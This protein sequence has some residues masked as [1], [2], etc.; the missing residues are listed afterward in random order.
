[1][2]ISGYMRDAKTK[3]TDS[4]F[5]AKVT[6]IEKATASSVEN[7]SNVQIDR[8]FENGVSVVNYFGH[9]SLNA[10]EFNLD[11]PSRFNNQGKYPLFLANA[12]TAG[13]N[14]FYDSLRILSNKKSISEAY[15]LEPQK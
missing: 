3:I 11:D 13:N 2:I 6:T 9:S 4:L 15:V 5:G 8:E 14:F 7:A 1:S 10:M 12:C